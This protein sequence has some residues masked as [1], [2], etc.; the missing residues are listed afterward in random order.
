MIISVIIFGLNR[1][2]LDHHKIFRNK[3][4]VNTQRYTIRLVIGQS[5]RKMAIYNRSELTKIY[6]DEFIGLLWQRVKNTKPE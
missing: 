3:I 6:F 2:Y 1:P 5:L 4:P